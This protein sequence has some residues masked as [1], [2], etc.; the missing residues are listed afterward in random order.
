MLYTWP[1]VLARL[2]PYP[3]GHVVRVPK[4]TIAPPLACGAR[5]AAGLPLGQVADF[6]WTL[7]Q[8]ECLHVRDLGDAYEAH[9]D[10]I[11]PALRPI[12]HLAVDAPD[13][14]IGSS[15]ALGAGLGAAFGQD[16]ASAVAGALLGLLAGGIAVLVL[17]R[18]T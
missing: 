6:R 2:A 14:F 11:D 5:A 13:V 3:R 18:A 15:V 8:G 9:I 16:G 1:D 12:A 17:G 10:Q 4:T 7:P